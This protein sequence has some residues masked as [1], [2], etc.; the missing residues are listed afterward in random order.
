MFISLEYFSHVNHLIIILFSST[1]FLILVILLF[2]FSL[3]LISISLVFIIFSS[4]L[5]ISIANKITLLESGEI[6][7]SKNLGS[8]E[9]FILKS[10]SF[11]HIKI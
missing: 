3:L 8:I 7:I 2:I 4:N 9:F 10:N 6:A 5:H 11:F 1:Y